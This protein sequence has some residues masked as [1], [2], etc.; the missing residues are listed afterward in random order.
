MNF[1]ICNFIVKGGKVLETIFD[2]TILKEAAYNSKTSIKGRMY[3]YAFVAVPVLTEDKNDETY[4]DEK[5]YIESKIENQE[6]IQE[7]VIYSI[8]KM[9]KNDK[10]EIDALSTAISIEVMFNISDEKMG[11]SYSDGSFKK[12]TSEASYATYVLESTEDNRATAYDDFTEK[13]YSYTEYSDSISDGTNNIGELTGIKVAAENFNEKQF[14]V[15][16]S[17]SLYSLKS[18]REWIY[19]WKH[20]GYTN[21]ARKPIANKELIE[22][23]YTALS[24]DN[25]IILYKWTKGHAN[26]SFNEMCDKLAKSALGIKK[27]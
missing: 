1:L 22:E 2:E 11:I 5:Y 8:Y 3:T 24:K 4:N 14:Q 21:Y 9:L 27:K 19:T 12:D 13:S 15:I 26:D 6:S 25:K 7:N 23:T 18:F 16:I 17:D 10:L 20:N